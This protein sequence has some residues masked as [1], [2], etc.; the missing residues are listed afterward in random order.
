MLID[1]KVGINGCFAN[2]QIIR[3]VEKIE[4]ESGF[5]IG[6]GICWNPLKVSF[7]EPSEEWF[8][9]FYEWIKH[10]YFE[11][12]LPSPAEYKRKITM[13][14]PDKTWILE[15][16]WVNTIDFNDADNLKVSLIYD[17]YKEKQNGIGC[18]G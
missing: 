15:G 13:R 5:R 8:V 12:K 4:D 16:T 2:G 18:L 17:R 3:P 9:L 7:D 1:C 14:F 6:K 10:I 11:S